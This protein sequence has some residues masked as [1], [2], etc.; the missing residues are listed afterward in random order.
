MG[1]KGERRT[2]TGWLFCKHLQLG[3]RIFSTPRC[4]LNLSFMFC[5]EQKLFAQ[6]LS[7]RPRTA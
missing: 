7:A 5:S 3:L 4:W 1:H 6:R 2:G